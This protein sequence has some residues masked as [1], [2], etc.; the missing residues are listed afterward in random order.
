MR[1]FRIGLVSTLTVSLIACGEKPD[2]DDTGEKPNTP[3]EITSLSMS[4]T[5]VYTND[6][7]TATVESTDA[8]GDAVTLAYIWYVD[9]VEVDETGNTLVVAE[10]K[11][12]GYIGVTS[13]DNVFTNSNGN[14]YDLRVIAKIEP[15]EGK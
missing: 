8:D 9:G 15:T 3:P 14:Q 11:A 4:P 2:S 7:L 1:H 13:I 6:V 10:D 12:T 5:E